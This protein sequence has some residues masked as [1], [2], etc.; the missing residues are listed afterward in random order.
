M[1]DRESPLEF[2]CRFPIK[3]MGERQ[4]DFQEHVL[5]LINLHVTGISDDDI[6][7]RPSSK[8]NFTGLTVTIYA[9]SREQLDD[10]YRS[11]TASERVLFV[12]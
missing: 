12:L 6:A 2:P 9:E 11:L 7:V 5:S 10:V 1:A 3:I 8:G 4:P